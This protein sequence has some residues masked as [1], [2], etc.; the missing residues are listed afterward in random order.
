MSNGPISGSLYAQSSGR[1][2]AHTEHGDIQLFFES[3]PRVGFDVVGGTNQGTVK[4]EI[5]LTEAADDKPKQ[6]VSE[7]R[8]RSQG[9]A[10]KPIRMEV[11]ATTLAGNVVIASPK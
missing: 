9:Y 7:V 6:Y 8:A 4:V 2:K 10:E 5:G 1:V 11:A 3:E